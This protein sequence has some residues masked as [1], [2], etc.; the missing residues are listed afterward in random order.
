MTVDYVFWLAFAA[1]MVGIIALIAVLASRLHPVREAERPTCLCDE[2]IAKLIYESQ[3]RTL[4]WR[5][6]YFNRRDEENYLRAAAALREN[7]ILTPR[8]K[9]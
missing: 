3:W 4:K 7:F 1:L 2:Q 8:A 6:L 5:G 9:P